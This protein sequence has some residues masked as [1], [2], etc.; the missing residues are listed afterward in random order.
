MVDFDTVNHI[1]GDNF[2]QLCDS[3]LVELHPKLLNLLC[4][5]LHA[6]VLVLIKFSDKVFTDKNHIRPSTNIFSLKQIIV[7]EVGLVQIL[8]K[9]IKLL[10]GRL[11]PSVCILKETVR[12]A[13]Q[14]GDLLVDERQVLLQDHL[15]FLLL[16]FQQSLELVKLVLNHISQL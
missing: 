13:L 6:Y 14:F 10:L 11:G 1:T 15:C 12:N 7:D 8:L 5:S 3:S 9:L 2:I 16:N 4:N